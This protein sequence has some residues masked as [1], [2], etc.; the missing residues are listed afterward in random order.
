[1]AD[2]NQNDKAQAEIPTLEAAAEYS[3]IAK[4]KILDFTLRD[5]RYTVVTVSGQKIDRS[6][7]ERALEAKAAKK[8]GQ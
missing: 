7:A 1:M 4:S 2:V 8:A 5:G 6:A 3:G